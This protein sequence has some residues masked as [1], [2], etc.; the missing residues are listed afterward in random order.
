MPP[1]NLT[2]ILNAAAY[3][4]LNLQDS[5]F[6]CVRA[7]RSPHHT[8][9]KSSIFGGGSNVAKIGEIALANGGVLFFDEFPHFSKQIIESLREPLEDNKIHIA[10]VREFTKHGSK[11]SLQRKRD[12]A[13]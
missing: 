3:R 4:S 6:S 13:V 12:K 10:R 7:F 11:L 8:S 5:E 1:Q 9:T 2:E